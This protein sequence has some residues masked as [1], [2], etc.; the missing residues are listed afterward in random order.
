MRPPETGASVL[1]IALFFLFSG[2]VSRLFGARAFS[3][4]ISM[5]FAVFGAHLRPVNRLYFSSTG[6]F[7]TCRASMDA[8]QDDS[9]AIHRGGAQ[10]NVRA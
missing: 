3:F 6:L 4:A 10:R 9:R 7:R 2:P 1:F 5:A 8:I